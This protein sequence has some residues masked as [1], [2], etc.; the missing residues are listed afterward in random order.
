MYDGKAIPETFYALNS[1]SF[2]VRLSRRRLFKAGKNG[3]YSWHS[4]CHSATRG[5]ASIGVEVQ[6]MMYE[7][8]WF[9][10]KYVML[11]LILLMMML[12]KNECRHE[13]YFISYFSAT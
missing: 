9:V 5:V 3:F 1:N 13:I 7:S 4:R 2:V 8:K 10:C 6:R 12:R 11:L